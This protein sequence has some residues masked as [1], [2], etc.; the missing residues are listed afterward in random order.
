M[1]MEKYFS[2][3]VSSNLYVRAPFAYP[4]AGE[5]LAGQLLVG[6]RLVGELLVGDRLVGELFVGLLLEDPPPGGFVSGIL[7]IP[8]GSA[9]SRQDGGP[10]G[11]L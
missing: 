8:L 3:Y 10:V 7:T 2:G 9:T 6:D 11:S 4:L 1:E 5:L